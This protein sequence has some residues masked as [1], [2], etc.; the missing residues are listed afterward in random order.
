MAKLGASPRAPRDV[1]IVYTYLLSPVSSFFRPAGAPPPANDPAAYYLS[2]GDYVT[3]HARLT[4]LEARLLHALSFDTH[5]ALPHPLAVTYLQAL[6]FLGGPRDALARR[7]L[8]YL[9]TALLSPQLLYL[10]HAPCEL[11]VAAVYNAARDVGAKMPECA[12]WEV[13]DV[14]R[15][16]LGFL[17]VGMR[18][19]DGWVARQRAETPDLLEGMVTRR[20]IEGEMER[21]GLSVR[22]GGAGKATEGDEEEVL[23]RAMDQRM[24][25]VE[26]S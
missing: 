13:F 23:M 11:A 14:D 8:A 2:E 9:N 6:E 20:K 7:A 26:A 18:S 22:N 1:A 10:T 12:W 16:A 19:L 4:A 21:R 15:E 25:V 5:V 3:F 24:D 17:V